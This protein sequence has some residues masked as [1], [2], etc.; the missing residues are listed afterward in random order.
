MLGFWGNHSFS[1]YAVE[2]GIGDREMGEKQWEVELRV[3]GEPVLTIGTGGLSGDPEIMQHEDII[4]KAAEHLNGFAGTE[5]SRCFY[6]GGDG[7]IETDNNG[8]I[9]KCPVC[10]P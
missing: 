3:D 7:E 10:Q 8:P 2:C 6:C 4:R 9:V 5:D 1:Q